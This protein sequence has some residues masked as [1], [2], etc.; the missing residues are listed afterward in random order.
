MFDGWK[1]VGHRPDPDSDD[2]CSANLKLH[3]A[4]EFTAL[5]PILTCSM[6]A[7]VIRQLVDR[8]PGQP[9]LVRWPIMCDSLMSGASCTTA[10]AYILVGLTK[11]RYIEK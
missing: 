5:G 9:S 11:P 3:D 10:S 6:T 4:S 2:P 1:S 8:L 7:E